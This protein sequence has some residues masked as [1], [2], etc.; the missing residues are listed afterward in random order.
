LLS[1]SQH[2]AAAD[3]IPFHHVPRFLGEAERDSLLRMIEARVDL[4]REVTSRAG[5]GPRYRVIDGEQIQH[6][7]PAL[8][9]YG[10][11]ELRAAIERVTGLQLQLMDSPKRAIHVQVYGGPNE[12]FRW[13]FDGHT[14]AAL[15]TLRNTN[16]GATELVRPYLSRWLRL[17]LYAMYPWPQLF[18]LLPATRIVAAAGDLLILYGEQV[19]HRGVA[20]TRDGERWLAIFNYD[21]IGRRPNRLRDWLARRINY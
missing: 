14:L 19:L 3:M 13:H 18:S 7:L 6:C 5:F 4:L 2:D 1:I 15:L 11:R 8:R 17:P 12:G 21:A 9:A 20:G 10:E 16:G